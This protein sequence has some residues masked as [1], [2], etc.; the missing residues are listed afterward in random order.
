MSYETIIITHIFRVMCFI[1]LLRRRTER[2]F[3]L[4]N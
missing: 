4:N 3:F 2:F 1:Q